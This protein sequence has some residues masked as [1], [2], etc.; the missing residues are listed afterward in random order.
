VLPFS[1]LAFITVFIGVQLGS[2]VV[3]LPFSAPSASLP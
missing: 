1:S 2:S 3:P